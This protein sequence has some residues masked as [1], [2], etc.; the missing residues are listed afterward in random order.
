M[1]NIDINIKK[2]VQLGQENLKLQDKNEIIIEN[3]RIRVVDDLI[4]RNANNGKVIAGEYFGSKYTYDE[5]FKMFEDY[6]KAFLSLDGKEPSSIAIS[7][8]STIASVNAFYG[9]IDANKI[10][11]AFGPG[12]LSVFTEKYIKEF[13]TKTVVIY[14]GFLNEEFIQKLSLSGVKNVI[15]IS[16]TDYMN[17]L[18]KFI[19]TKKGLIPKGDFLDNYIK[20]GKK[21]PSGIQ[22]IRLKEFAK[23]LGTI[24]EKYKWERADVRP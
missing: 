11:N 13:D 2:I 8:P 7:S 22:F 18:V 24:L 4:K 16:V 3:P 19:G 9:A 23:E 20:S 12:F 6:K 5:T 17:P 14:D 15:V 1:R 21:L 10:V